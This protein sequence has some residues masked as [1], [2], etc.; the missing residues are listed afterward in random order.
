MTRP[1]IIVLLVLAATLLCAPLASAAETT[2]IS[3]AAVMAAFAKTKASKAAF[4]EEKHVSFVSTPLVSEGTLSYDGDILE[5][6]VLS[7]DEELMRIEGDRLSISKGRGSNPTEVSLSDYP[8]LDVFITA[9]RATLNGDLPKL[10]SVFD[11]HFTSEAQSW[12]FR[13]TPKQAE[14]RNVL[15]SAEFTGSGTRIAQLDVLERNGD[16]TIIKLRPLQ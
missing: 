7:P 3:L 6:H 10:E 11:I 14:I 9:L 13:L 16:R 1:R 4:V 5:K 15:T 2:D 12:Q 8:A